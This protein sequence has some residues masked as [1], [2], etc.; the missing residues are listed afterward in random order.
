MSNHMAS[1]GEWFREM[2]DPKIPDYVKTSYDRAHPIAHIQKV[3][4]S[5]QGGK[6]KY[7]FDVRHVLDIT[8]NLIFVGQIIEQG[9]YVHFNLDG[10]YVEDC[11]DDCI[12]DIKGKKVGT[13]FTLDIPKVKTAIFAQGARVVAG[14]RGVHYM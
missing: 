13:I 10:C 11:K 14:A 1:C 2:K 4:L 8:K 9:L 12:L 3:P 7:L 6:M 5:M